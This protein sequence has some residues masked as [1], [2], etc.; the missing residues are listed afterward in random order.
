V[1]NIQKT[2][3]VFCLIPHP[4]LSLFRVI[5]HNKNG[6]VVCS[7]LLVLYVYII[8]ICYFSKKF[9]SSH[10][11]QSTVVSSIFKYNGPVFDFLAGFFAVTGV[12]LRVLQR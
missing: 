5:L 12:G 11:S 2:G 6:G 9:P 8:L 1:T 4:L 7:T 10:S 3:E